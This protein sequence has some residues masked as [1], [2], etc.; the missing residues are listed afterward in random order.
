M[1]HDAVRLAYVKRLA[2]AGAALLATPVRADESTAIDRLLHFVM[3]GCMAHVV[4]NAPV[5]AFAAREQARRAGTRETKALLGDEKGA[6]YA[7]GDTAYPLALVERPG[8]T[9]AVHA[10]VPAGLETVIAA[11]DDYFVGPGS[12]FY[13]GRVFEE[14][15]PHGGWITQRVYL[16]R[17]DGKNITVL[18]STDPKA[19][20]LQQI[21]FTLSSEDAPSPPR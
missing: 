10:H 21:V 14:A 13:P 17:R 19:P 5:G 11:A 15:S 12:R 6:V 7:T 4:Q 2:L 1:A 8:A 3:N 16:G 18:F 20:G 9:C